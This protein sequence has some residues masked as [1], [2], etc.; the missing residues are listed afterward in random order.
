MRQMV[1]ASK[2][3]YA[4]VKSSDVLVLF[5]HLPALCALSNQVLDAF[6]PTTPDVSG[7]LPWRVPIGKVFC[8]LA[9]PLVVFLQYTLHYQTH[10]KSIK[11]ACNNALF[12]KINQ[13]TLRRRDSNRLGMSDYLIAPI[14]RVPRYCMLLKDL[15]KYT[16]PSDED[17]EPLTKALCTMTSLVMAMDHAQCC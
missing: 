8:R 6:G 5:S 3:K 14:Q 9:Q 10:Q 7:W 16:D 15:L 2:E 12:V 4:L 13:D 11:K 1:H 17:Y